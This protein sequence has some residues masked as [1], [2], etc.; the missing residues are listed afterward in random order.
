MIKRFSHDVAIGVAIVTSGIELQKAM[1][2]THSMFPKNW[3]G[4]V[5]I[6]SCLMALILAGTATSAI[7]EVKFELSRPGHIHPKPF[8]GRVLVMLG[9]RIPGHQNQVLTGST[10]SPCLR[11]T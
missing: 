5:L 9:Q 8:T 6:A 7:A 11:S 1:N 3:P 4:R 2:K 10:H